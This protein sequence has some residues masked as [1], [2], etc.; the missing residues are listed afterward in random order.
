MGCVAL[1]YRASRALRLYATHDRETLPGNVETVAENRPPGPR[2]APPGDELRYAR[3]TKKY[4]LDVDRH[5][6]QTHTLLS[7]TISQPGTRYQPRVPTPSN[8][9][10]LPER[11]PR[12]EVARGGLAAMASAAGHRHTPAHITEP[13][14]SP[15]GEYRHHTRLEHHAASQ[16]KHE[17]DR[18]LLRPWQGFSQLSSYSGACGP[19]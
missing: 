15:A 18:A 11:A 3:E 13:Y 12:A 16:P 1:N 9:C 6:I 14:S 2:A 10:T 8:A 4:L 5:F 7:A 17:V 19:H